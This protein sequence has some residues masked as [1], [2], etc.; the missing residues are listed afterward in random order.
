M[1]IPEEAPAEDIGYDGDNILNE[2][3]R[4]KSVMERRTEVK[5]RI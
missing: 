5:R 1:I 3:N 4:K 2:T